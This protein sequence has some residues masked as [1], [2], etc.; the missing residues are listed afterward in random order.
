MAVNQHVDEHSQTP[1]VVRDDGRRPG[2]GPD[3]DA[4]VGRGHPREL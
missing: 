1:C 4:H 3:T 2:T